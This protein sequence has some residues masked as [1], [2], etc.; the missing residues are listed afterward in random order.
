LGENKIGLGERKIGYG[1]V[2]KWKNKE[3]GGS[4]GDKKG[5]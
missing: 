1:S 4:V 3:R 2:G 5:K